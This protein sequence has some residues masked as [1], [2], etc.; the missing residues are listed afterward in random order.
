[1]REGPAASSSP[2]SLPRIFVQI[3]SYRDREC[4][5]TVR[6]LFQKARHPERIFVG[7]CWQFDP[8]L[9][10][11]CFRIETRPAQVRRV[12]FHARDAIGLGWARLQAQEL[13]QGEEYT[14][15]IDSHMR[16]APDWDHLMLE[17][18]AA[19][20]SD[21]PV[22]TLYP[23]AYWPPDRLDEATFTS[24]AVQVVKRIGPDGMPWCTV[25]FAPPEVPVSA[26]KPASGVAGGFIFAP[27]RMIRDVPSDPEVYFIGEEPNLAVR[28][29]THGFDLFS[30]RTSLIYHYYRRVDSR[31]PWDDA[32]PRPMTER[33]ATR[34]RQLLRPRPGDA[35]ELGRYGLGPARSLAEYETF[36]GVSIAARSIASYA[37]FY[38]FV[39]TDETA[40][41]L[42]DTVGLTIADEAMLF[43]FGEE[44]VLFSGRRQRFYRLNQSATLL[45]CLLE[46]GLALDAIIERYRA[47]AGDIP[48]ADAR[49][50]VQSQICHFHSWGVMAGYAPPDMNDTEAGD[51]PVEDRSIAWAPRLPTSPPPIERHYRIFGRRFRVL[52][53]GEHYAEAIEPL[54]VPL[55]VATDDAAAAEHTIKVM[56]VGPFHY[57]IL[58][59]VFPPDIVL[60]ETMVAAQL[61]ASIRKALVQDSS[62][63]VHV[64]GAVAAGPGGD[65]AILVGPGV[66]AVR[67]SLRRDSTPTGSLAGQCLHYDETLQGVDL[68]QIDRTDGSLRVL[69]APVVVPDGWAGG[70]EPLHA[71]LAELPLH[72]GFGPSQARLPAL[73]ESTTTQSPRPRWLIS[74]RIDPDRYTAAEFTTLSVADALTDLMDCAN[75]RPRPSR[76]DDAMALVDWVEATP[77]LLLLTAPSTAAAATL[78]SELMAS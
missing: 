77:S 16:F 2:T 9:D 44:G 47:A 26:P 14:L 61:L 7:I 28:L 43:V 45:W 41:T 22:L 3:P 23:A 75:R 39:Y 68:I 42:I 4:Q 25:R 11:D 29:Y 35:A 37:L 76:A 59:D 8:E 49:R 73:G 48:E 32:D 20:P 6:D 34:M 13:W 69:P 10:Q 51:E 31:R 36:A 30:P 56:G 62:A 53:C 38:P 15:H 74:L 54:L 63:L 58:D 72:A 65:A 5:Y 17:E 55:A 66:N 21:W 12:D 18:L 24:S 67:V 57:L 50:I 71:A 46:E 33:T 70:T 64:L 40:R 60:S 19:C 27:S 1:M 52:F 78:I